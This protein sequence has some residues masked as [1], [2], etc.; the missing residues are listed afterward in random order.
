MEYEIQ[1]HRRAAWQIPRWGLS[2]YLL[3]ELYLTLREV[4][5]A[6]PAEHLTHDPE[7]DGAFFSLM[8]T[9]PESPF[10]R[11]IFHFRVYFTPTDPHINIV[12]GS[13]YR[14]FVPGSFNDR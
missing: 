6:N 12:E 7:G 10:F 13:Y 5:A 3:V 11:H 14:V 2:D 1:F 4:L 8:R 9:D